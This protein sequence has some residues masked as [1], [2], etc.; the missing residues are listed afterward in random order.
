MSKD[1]ARNSRKLIS[2]KICLFQSP[3]FLKKG[4]EKATATRSH[5]EID[6]VGRN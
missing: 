6:K 2:P 3:A 1:A 5:K 4:A